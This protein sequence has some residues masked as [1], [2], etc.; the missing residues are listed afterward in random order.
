MVVTETQ[1][2]GLITA[3][4]AF[5]Q[6]VTIAISIW[7]RNHIATVAAEQKRVADNLQQV[8]AD[9]VELRKFLQENAKKA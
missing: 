6:V 8:T 4:I 3:I 2:A 7:N 1:I 9:G 5:L